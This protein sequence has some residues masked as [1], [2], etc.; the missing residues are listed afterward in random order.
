LPKP[1]AV[2]E[3][4]Q[5]YSLSQLSDEKGLILAW[6]GDGGEPTRHALA[7]FE[8]LRSP[9]EKW[10]G[11]LALCVQEIPTGEAGHLDKMRDMAQQARLLLDSN[12]Q[13][14]GHFLNDIKRPP[15]DQRPVIMGISKTGEVIYYSEGYRIGVGEQVLKA[16]RR[17]ENN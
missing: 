2:W 13:L 9:I 12:G 5:P 15:T 11:G 8:Q 17:I 10:G 4:G 16:I 14:L 3:E 6:I 7:D 1:G